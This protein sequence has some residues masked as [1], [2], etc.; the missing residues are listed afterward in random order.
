M[1]PKSP[2]RCPSSQGR[3]RLLASQSRRFGSA[4]TT[5]DREA[6]SCE[7]S[8]RVSQDLQ[9]LYRQPRSSATAMET[10]LSYL[11]REGRV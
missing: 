6:P 11:S 1:R 5:R 9:T 8:S 4:R 2:L 10:A 7:V 3:S